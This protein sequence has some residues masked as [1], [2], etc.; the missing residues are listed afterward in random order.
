MRLFSSF[1]VLTTRRI[2]IL[3]LVFSSSAHAIPIIDSGTGRL[4]GATN[5]MVQGFAYDVEFLNGTC[6]DIFS[7]CDH[8]LDF[9]FSDL[10]SV[11]AAGFALLDQVLLDADGHLFDS[12]AGMTAGCGGPLLSTSTSCYIHTP[13]SRLQ[14]GSTTERS[15]YYDLTLNGGSTHIDMDWVIGGGPFGQPLNPSTGGSSITWAR[16]TESPTTVPEP[17]TLAL[18]ACALIGIA[19]V[20]RV[21][22][23]Q[24][25]S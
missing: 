1:E 2:A 8:P 3:A 5:V 7:G 11:R 6:A 21:P 24:W 20:R 14:L 25:N 16:W 15:L 17:S 22:R 18:F 9:A 4:L 19:L 12:L 23:G 10:G 13:F